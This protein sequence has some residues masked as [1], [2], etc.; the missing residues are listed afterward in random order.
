MHATS[1]AEL[2]LTITDVAHGGVFI[3]RHEGRVVFVSDAIPGETVRARV[4]DDSKSSFWRA[5]TVEVLDASPN[6]QKH[7]WSAADVSVA[8][9]IRPGGAEFGHIKINHQRALKTKVL[10]D[11]L[12]RF[13]KI[14]SDVTVA[15]VGGEADGT[16]W[17]T[18]VS[19][20]VDDAGRIGPYASRSHRVIE[21]NDLPLATMGVERAADKLYAT[22]ADRIDLVQG[23][24]GHVRVLNRKLGPKG[25]PIERQSSQ[26]EV[27]TER[28]GEREF[29]VDADG[30]WQV[31]HEAASTLDGAVRRAL[32]GVEIDPEAWHLDLYGGVGLFA[33]TIA[34]L[35][36]TR[37]TSIEGSASATEHAGENLSEWIGARAETERVDRYTRGLLEKASEREKARLR[38][39]V[40]VMDP[41]RAGAGKHVVSNLATLEPRAIVYVACDPVALAR[42]LG[43]FAERGYQLAGIEAFDL[44]PHSHHL[45]TVAL[46]QKS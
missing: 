42:D 28:V 14:D 32:A 25:V 43:T 2:E 9:S 35:G 4:L 37:V 41:P 45:E 8:P 33:A 19:L 18:R 21:V 26:R 44:F 5:D 20:H 24:D 22:D 11:S 3:A 29:R 36:G 46:L 10:Q 27:L 12:A 1:P 23:A 30:F 40:V 16:R 34:E 7:V 17:R 38:G 15:G 39:G 6:R 13:A 31:H